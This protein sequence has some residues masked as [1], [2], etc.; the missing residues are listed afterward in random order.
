MFSAL[1]FDVYQP[2]DKIL[3]KFSGSNNLELVPKLRILFGSC[4]IDFLKPSF[5]Y[6]LIKEIL[7]PYF[8]FQI[9]SIVV[10]FYIE[11]Y[12]FATF[13]AFISLLSAFINLYMLRANLTRIHELVYYKITVDVYRKDG[14]KVQKFQEVPSTE[15]VPGDVIVIKDHMRLPC[16][17]LLLSGQALVDEVA[18]TGESVPVSKF[19][20]P[21]TG[22]QY[23]NIHKAYT[24]HEGTFVLQTFGMK[25]EETLGLVIRTGFSTLRGQLIRGILFP[26][27]HHL[28]FQRHSYWFTLVLIVMSLIGFSYSAPSLWNKIARKEFVI[29][30]LDLITIAIPPSLP[31]ALTIT[32]TFSLL[33]IKRANVDCI[34]PQ[35]IM[36]AGRVDCMCFDK[37]GT[38]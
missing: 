26:K 14:A 23:L 11:Y 33:R 3:A 28:R 10:W 5:L 35:R 13:I 1:E 31:A 2:F 24:V 12:V 19:G 30:C 16:D 20:I 27:P 8:L 6:L 4:A 18:L 21:N 15:L 9:Y 29:I 38:S 25:A 22:D 37:T 7:H 34:S 36:A 17:C 32:M